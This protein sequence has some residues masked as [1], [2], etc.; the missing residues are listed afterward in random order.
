MST[1]A[2]IAVIGAG[3]AG[4]TAAYCLA[5]AGYTNLDVYEAADA[6]GGL[7]RSIDLWNQRIDI[8]PHRF[9]SSDKP[10]NEL[11]LEVAAGDYQMV[12]RLTRIYYKKKFFYYPLKAFNALFNLG[13]FQAI[14]CVLSYFWQKVAPA[15]DNGTFENWVTRRFGSRLYKI[16]FKTYT[17]KLWGISCQTLDSDFAAQRIKK[18]SLYEAVKNALIGGKQNKHK[19]LVDQFAYP[20]QGTG[21]IYERM[22]DY[23]RA[24]GGAVHLKTPVKGVEKQGATI[25]GIRLQDDTVKPYD[26]VISTMPMTLMVQ[27]LP[28]VPP[29]I[30]EYTR[31]LQ[32]RNTI[33]VYLNIDAVDLFPDQWLYV[34]SADMDTGRITNF[35]NWIPEVYG[36]EKTSILAM[37]Y[38]CYDPDAMWQASDA[39]LIEQ[40]SSEI[41]KTGLI[42][43]ARILAG[44]VYRIPRS[45][46]VYA[47]GYRDNLKPVE[48]YLQTIQNLHVIGR[49]G[50]FKYNNQDHS[51]L[52]GILAA[53]NIA[54][55]K[56]HNLWDI[57][58]DY[59]TYQ[60]SYVITST[61][62]SKK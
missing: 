46:P 9:F 32:F 2:K 53:E 35:R 54:E 43:D 14:L 33:I 17:E 47:T 51:I 28:S 59:E 39:E 36:E 31:K 48:E 24:K 5:R 49:Y 25:S 30:L 13:V 50:A 7:S 44:H 56:N 26:H 21:M 23:V 15:P 29:E 45:Y 20:N 22:A 12:N 8:G 41:R 11:W 42:K 58:T 60:E 16:F 3:P 52:M 34:H 10:V 38:W 61:G 37:E 62:L 57:N 6:V 18:L 4:M 27:S 55:N 40:A 19:T 1:N